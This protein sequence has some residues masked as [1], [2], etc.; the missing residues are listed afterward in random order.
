MASWLS[1][2]LAYA[3]LSDGT[4]RATAA[5]LRISGLFNRQRQA[6][7]HELAMRAWADALAVT[8]EEPACVW[9]SRGG[10]S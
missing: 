8:I 10:V 1:S 5:A 2:F 3:D 4:L 7:E 6:I 9:T